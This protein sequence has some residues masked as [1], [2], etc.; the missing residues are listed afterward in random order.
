MLCSSP[1]NF[2]SLSLLSISIRLSLKIPQINILTKR[3]LIIDRVPKILEWSSEQIALE[4][5][6]N[7]EKNSEYALLSK[8]IIN[9]IYGNGLMEGLIPFSN[10]T[11]NGIIDISAELTRII[12]QGEEKKY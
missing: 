9:N 5:D 10:I 8:E 6:L 7:N 4:D 2:V 12:N 11:M 1:V 3:D